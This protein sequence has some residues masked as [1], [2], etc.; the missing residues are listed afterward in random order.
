[1]KS[2]GL[3]FR[4]DELVMVSLKQGISAI[5]L[6]GYRVLPLQDFKDEEKDEAVLHNLQRFLKIYKGGDNLF[7][8]LPRDAVLVKF[9]HLPAA[10][11]ENLRATLGYELDKHTPFSFDEVY[12]DY[13]ILKQIPES[14]LLYVMLITVK[15]E[16]VDYYLNLLKKIKIKPQGIEITTTALFNVFQKAQSAPEQRTAL[17]LPAGIKER[18]VSSLARLVPQLAGLIKTPGDHA[19][20]PRINILVEY[21]DKNNYELAI[22]DENSL[23]YSQVLPCAGQTGA[24]SQHF[25]E[26]YANGAQGIINLP[27]SHTGDEHTLGFFLS[28]REMGKENLES[29][30]EDMRPHFS[31][32]RE[33]PVRLDK[34][35]DEAIAAALPL[36]AVPVGL[37]LKGLQG[38]ACDIN[39]IPQPLRPKRKRSKRKMLALAGIVLFCLA[40]TGFFVKST[41]HM[42]SRLA[43]LNAEVGELKA[44]VQ[45]IENLQKEAQK[46]EQFS[47]AIKSIRDN[48]ISKLKLLEELTR[49]IPEDSWLTEFAYK[50]DEK[51]VK[52]SGFAVSAAKLIPLLE[53]SPVFD[54][55][56]FTSPITADKRT[57]KDRFRLEMNVSE[58]AK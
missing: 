43:V 29:I 38:M 12:F 50:A 28:G 35:K 7:I 18:Y 31:L 39:F 52:L 57:N 27:Y 11:E 56:K 49:I 55:V 37:A 15:K 10:V 25:R 33:L 36:I 42:K 40:G 5:Y 24:D 3:V 26:L 48:D 58:G 19:L 54:S 14:N 46:I 4:K 17:P 13:H 1:M 45:T 34:Y 16:V 8:A 44:Q 47:A 21:L 51:K 6:E 30:S 20:H 22:A 9:L 41:L 2:I 32:M 23:Y 53:E